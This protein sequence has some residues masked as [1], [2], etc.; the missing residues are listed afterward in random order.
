MCCYSETTYSLLTHPVDAGYPSEYLPPLDP[1]LFASN[2]KLNYVD[3]CVKSEHC[4]LYRYVR[5]V[6]TCDNY[7]A[8]NIGMADCVL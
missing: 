1:S 4:S 5:P 7:A 3:C 8:P 6:P 2:D